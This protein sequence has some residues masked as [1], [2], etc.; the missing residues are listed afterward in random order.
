MAVLLTFA[1]S[2]ILA[3]GQAPVES[4]V[5]YWVGSGSA[6]CYLVVNFCD[7][8]SALVWGYKYDGSANKTVANMLTEID[9]ADDRLSI[10]GVAGGFITNFQFND[11]THNNWDF[12]TDNSWIMYSINNEFR[13]GVSTENIADGDVIEFGGVSCKIGSGGSDAWNL[14]LSYV[15]ATSAAPTS[16]NVTV[17]GSYNGTITPEGLNRV[18]SGDSLVIKIKPNQGYHLGELLVG[19]NNVTSQVVGDSMFVLRNITSDTNVSLRLAV[20]KNNTIAP[21]DIAYWVGSGNK[22]AI[23]ILNS[24]TPDTALAWGVRFS[25]DSILTQSLMDTIKSKDVRFTY[26]LGANGWLQSMSFTENA[27]VLNNA[28]EVMMFNVNEEPTNFGVTQMWV[29][30]DSKVEF[31]GYSCAKS[32]DYY[33]S[34]WT[35]NVTPVPVPT[36]LT[37][38]V[39]SS[40]Y[41]RVTPGGITNVNSGDSL[42]IKIKPDQGYHLG[43]ILIGTENVT[44][45]VVGDSVFVLRNITESKNVSVKFA[46]NK[47][48]TITPADITYWVGSGSN[49]AIVILNSCSPNIALAWG[50]K[51]RTDSVLVKSLLDTIKAKDSR[52]TYELSDNIVSDISF[53]ENGVVMGNSDLTIM[54]NVDEQTTI[55]EVTDMWVKPNSIVE[56]GG[57]SCAI[58]DDYHTNVWT[59]VVTPVAAPAVTAAPIAT[60]VS[61]KVYPNPAVDFVRVESERDFVG[62]AQIISLEGRVLRKA[63]LIGTTEIYVADLPTGVYSLRVVGKDGNC[64]YTEKMVLY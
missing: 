17:N 59:I 11:A 51:F 44:S 24:C 5:K 23:V 42:V 39:A 15:P 46:V 7:Y 49:E 57:Y 62:E 28:G 19:T 16:F 2:G 9:N 12:V 29:K 64:V 10:T 48:N 43:E 37:V 22:E 33:T 53:T 25:T 63:K 30:P 58:T 1:L 4:S 54:Y 45:Q 60:S 21:A 47:N 32:D 55:Q 13:G 3:F 20:N 61:I 26:S 40:S 38:R 18:N 34:V 41:G 36:N 31:G 6:K 35:T 27:F 14:P 52:F 8:N 56:F 50:V